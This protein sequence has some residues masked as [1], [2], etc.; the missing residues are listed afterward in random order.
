MDTCL[1]NFPFFGCMHD[2]RIIE[3]LIRL[4]TFLSLS[5]NLLVDPDFNYEMKHRQNSW[6]RVVSL[7][8]A[9]GLPVPS[10]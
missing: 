5:V 7:S 9:V 1:S 6:R 4:E 10:M 2:I 3:H 8:A